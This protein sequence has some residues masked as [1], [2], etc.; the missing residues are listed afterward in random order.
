MGQK[1]WC[2]KSLAS[3][4]ESQHRHQMALAVIVFSTTTYSQNKI[5]VPVRSTPTKLWSNT[6]I[7]SQPL[8]TQIYDL[9][10]EVGSIYIAFF[11]TLWSTMVVLK[12]I[13][14]AIIWVVSWTSCCF[15]RKEFFLK[16]LLTNYGYSG[17]DIEQILY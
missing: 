13:T 5:P 1:Q 6:L 3:W 9:G 16:K 15:H 4:H 10:E 2:V 12:K 17:M 14:C 8:S 11:A 7:K